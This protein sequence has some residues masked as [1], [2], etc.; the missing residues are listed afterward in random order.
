MQ[1]LDAYS[2]SMQSMRLRKPEQLEM[3]AVIGYSDQIKKLAI[4]K[5]AP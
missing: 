3:F 2:E 1:W 5:S 4:R